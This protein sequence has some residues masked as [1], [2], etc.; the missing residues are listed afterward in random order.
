MWT[1]TL[2]SAAQGSGCFSAEKKYTLSA[3]PGLRVKVKEEDPDIATGCAKGLRQG[4]E[5][6]CKS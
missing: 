3:E 5:Q 2:G 4:E 6:V 1:R